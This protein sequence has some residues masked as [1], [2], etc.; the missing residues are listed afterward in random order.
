MMDLHGTVQNLVQA[1]VTLLTCDRRLWLF[2][3]PNSPQFMVASRCRRTSG[4]STGRL[5][6]A[7]GVVNPLRNRLEHLIP[8]I[9]VLE[10]LLRDNGF[11]VPTRT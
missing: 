8:A 11:T 9:P 4:S 3:S 7:T 1:D 5:I 6:S 10:K 2:E